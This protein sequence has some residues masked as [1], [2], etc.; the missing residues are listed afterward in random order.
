MEGGRRLTSFSHGA[1]CGCKLGPD[2]LAEVL[3]GVSLP[4]APPEL[5]VGTDTG[6][7]AAVWRTSDG[8]ALVATLDYFTPIVDDPYDWG[9]IAA[10]NAMSDV[11]AM[12]GTPFLGLNIVNWPVDDL[13]TEML[14]R[15]LQGGVDAA[16]GAGVAVVGGHSITDPEP[17][18]GMVVVGS[19]DPDRMFTN[20]SARPGDRLYLTKP[21]GLGIISTAVKRGVAPADLITTAVDLMTTTNA[22]GA[23]AMVEAQASAATDITGFGLLGHLH[24]MLLASGC[25]ATV[26]A[27]DVPLIDGVRGLA[28]DGVVPGGTQRNH[29]FVDAATDWAGLD[30]EEQLVL[31]DA[32]TSGGLLI[33]TPDPEALEAALTA[34]GVLVAPIGEVVLGPAG[35]IRVEGRLAG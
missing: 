31:A 21:L 18:Y 23:A 9:R 7:D 4:T 29:D 16:T 32:Q 27:G 25:G 30:R 28:R 8:H 24:K 14:G 17:K 3:R 33:A 2:Q 22:A 19:V 6:D 35:S 11:Y 15:V 20:A 5:L 10:T 12:G 1:G 34:R 26:R 13:P